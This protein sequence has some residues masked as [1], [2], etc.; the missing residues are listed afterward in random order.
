[1]P[2]FAIEGRSRIPL[3]DARRAIKRTGGPTGHRVDIFCEGRSEPDMTCTVEAG[4]ALTVRSEGLPRFV[5]YREY[6]RLDADD[7]AEA[8]E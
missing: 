7:I 6:D 8:A 1:M 3:L 5:K 4:A 2:G